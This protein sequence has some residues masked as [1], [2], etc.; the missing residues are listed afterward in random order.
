[1]GM[2]IR[3]RVVSLVYKIL[4][5]VLC[6]L[7]LL[8][9]SG[10]LEGNF[11][12][13]VFSYYT[14]A[15]NCLCFIF[16]FASVIGLI[17]DL[18]KRGVRG[19]SSFGIH[20]KGA[21]IVAMCA[22]VALYLLVLPA[23]FNTTGGTVANF[24]PANFLAHLVVPAMVLA[25]WLLFDKK[26]WYRP[27]DPIVWLLIPYLYYAFILVRAQFGVLYLDGSNYPYAFINADQLGWARV[28]ANIGI[29]SL[30]FLAV[31]Y[32]LFAIDAIWGSIIKKKQKQR[33]Q[34]AAALAE[35][36][37]LETPSGQLNNARESLIAAALAPPPPTAEAPYYFE[38]VSPAAT[39]QEPAGTARPTAPYTGEGG[40]AALEYGNTEPLNPPE[41][42]YSQPSLS[43]LP[44]FSDFEA[45][46]PSYETQQA[47]VQPPVQYPVHP[48]FEPDAPG[49]AEPHAAPVAAEPAVFTSPPPSASFAP[50]ASTAA[51]AEVV[52]SVD[53]FA[54]PASFEAPLAEA[55]SSYTYNSFPV[56]P[57]AA[58]STATAAA[59]EAAPP[60]DAFAAPASFEAQ[61]EAPSSYPYSHSSVAP[62]TAPAPLFTESTWAVGHNAEAAPLTATQQ[63]V[64]P[65]AAPSAVPQ[66]TFHT[67]VLPVFP[68]PFVNT[69][70]AASPQTPET[71]EAFTAASAAAPKAP[72]P[73]NGQQAPAPQAPVAS[74]PAQ[75]PRA[76]QPPLYGFAPATPVQYPPAGPAPSWKN[77]SPAPSAPAPAP[78][79]ILSGYAPSQPQ[80][81]QAP[82]ASQPWQPQQQPQPWAPNRPCRAAGNRIK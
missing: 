64:A 20:F 25:D 8:L 71:G 6:G 19:T 70:A 37:A 26:G 3:N 7:G 17:A 63:P 24:T 56:E 69:Q 30:L 41:E 75:A 73:G 31:G 22:V 81:S 27:S 51:A 79:P 62:E 48:F 42:P 38:G 66:P 1:M 36:T 35:G 44:L 28:L 21:L 45:S 10:I 33:H 2:C 58:S 78:A 9:Y 60:V 12:V 68:L 65:V 18:A 74:S 47:A 61:A 77:I 14:I 76:E 43:P 57:E 67:P 23:V 5:L 39:A 4:L 55:P 29:L 59:A 32:I 72:E 52:P 16:Y 53:A 46:E 49:A 80:P 40:A 54:A 50:A 15:V 82:A 13:S 11:D 34:E